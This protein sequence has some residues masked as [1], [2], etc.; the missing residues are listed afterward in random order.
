MQ[1]TGGAGRTKI[2]FKHWIDA[3]MKTQCRKLWA[4]KSAALIQQSFGSSVVKW[5]DQPKIHHDALPQGLVSAQRKHGTSHI[6]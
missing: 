4:G 2:A 6:I 1:D 3:A 5:A